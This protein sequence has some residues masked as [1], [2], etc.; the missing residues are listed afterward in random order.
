[1][2]KENEHPA[3]ELP[4]GLPGGGSG[5]SALDDMPSTGGGQLWDIK[6]LIVSLA[7]TLLFLPFIDAVGNGLSSR[8]MWEILLALSNI[9]E[10][11]YGMYIG[12]TANYI[13][14]FFLSLGLYK[15]SGRRI[16]WMVGQ[17]I[18]IGKGGLTIVGVVAPLLFTIMIIV[19]TYA[20][21]AAILSFL[22]SFTGSL[23]R[24]VEM[25]YVML[26]RAMSANMATIV[27]FGA[28]LSGLIIYWFIC[29]TRQGSG[30]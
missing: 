9:T 22:L 8:I 16:S 2:N 4:S 30:M 25:F 15:L 13:T 19:F 3:S 10:A 27:L 5:I 12:Y 20:A 24:F 29:K 1:M 11:E 28:V 18:D 6:V 17:L 7:I 21:V 14:F 26:F 23:F